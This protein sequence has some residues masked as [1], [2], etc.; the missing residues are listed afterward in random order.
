MDTMEVLRD[1]FGLDL[2][3]A[4]KHDGIRGVEFFLRA[5]LH[6]AATKAHGLGQPCGGNEVELAHLAD[7]MAHLVLGL[8]VAS[9]LE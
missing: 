5:Q 4:Y 3:G 1:R 2:P 9:R 6:S 8:H 7:F